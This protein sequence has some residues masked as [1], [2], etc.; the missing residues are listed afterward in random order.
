MTRP[1]TFVLMSS[2]PTSSWRLLLSCSLQPSAV[3]RYCR[4]RYCSRH[5]C[6]RCHCRCRRRCRR[7]RWKATTPPIGVYSLRCPFGDA[8]AK[9]LSPLDTT[10]NHGN[11]IQTQLLEYGHKHQSCI[12]NQGEGKSAGAGGA[13]RSRSRSLLDTWFKVYGYLAPRSRHCS[14]F[15]MPRHAGIRCK[16]MYCICTRCSSGTCFW[17]ACDYHATETQDRAGC[18][19]VA[20]VRVSIIQ[21]LLPPVQMS[22]R[23]PSLFLYLDAPNPISPLSR[24]EAYAS[25]HLWGKHKETA[26]EESREERKKDVSSSDPTSQGGKPK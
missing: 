16:D 23:Y 12:R 26:R 22:P 10:N 14:S 5:H 15:V 24:Q 7:Y 8:R 25:T 3:L 21:N 17:I 4:R 18:L 1:G 6:C 19:L 2:F 9:L 11:R 20:I 13:S